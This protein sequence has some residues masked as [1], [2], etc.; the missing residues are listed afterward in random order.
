[1]LVYGKGKT[2]IYQQFKELSFHWKMPNRKFGRNTN[3]ATFQKIFKTNRKSKK[4]YRSTE[5]IQKIPKNK[6]QKWWKEV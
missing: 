4:K 6:T 2:M 5:I 1:M 3:R